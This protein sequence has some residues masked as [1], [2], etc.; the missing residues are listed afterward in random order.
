[1]RVNG[2]GSIR[3]G[4]MNKEGEHLNKAFERNRSRLAFVDI[5]IAVVLVLGATVTIWLIILEY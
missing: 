4:C 5:S 2:L 1:M 3:E